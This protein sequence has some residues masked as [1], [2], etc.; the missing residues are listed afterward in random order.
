MENQF[1]LEKDP[2]ENKMNG[3]AGK[4]SSPRNCFSKE[5]RKNYDQIKWSKRKK[6]DERRTKKVN[7]LGN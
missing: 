6:K 5:F 3:Q 7:R 4:G 2:P 1:L